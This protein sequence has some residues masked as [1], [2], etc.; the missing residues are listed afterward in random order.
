MHPFPDTLQ[1]PYPQNHINPSTLAADGNTPA[2]PTINKQQV[3]QQ[4]KRYSGG[5][6]QYNDQGLVFQISKLEFRPRC[7]S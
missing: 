5:T 2:R 6:S 7:Q 3:L 1:G 4:S